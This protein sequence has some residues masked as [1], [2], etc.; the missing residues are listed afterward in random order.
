MASK[1]L[2]SDAHLHVIFIVIVTIVTFTNALIILFFTEQRNL[3]FNDAH[4]AS[5]IF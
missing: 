4:G 3:M 1:C 5:G 2:I